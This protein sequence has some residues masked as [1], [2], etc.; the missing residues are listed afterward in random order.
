MILAARPGKH[1]SDLF[2]TLALGLILTVAIAIFYSR[3]RHAGYIWDDEQHLTQNPVIVGPLGF[4]KIWTSAR[5]VY[6]PLV[7]TTF[8]T[9]HKFVG[10]NPLPYHALNVAWH[11][12]SA[13]LFWRVLAQLRIRAA[14]LGAAIWA[15]HPVVVQS[16]A[17][18]TEMKNTQS[19][20]FYLLAISLF[21]QSRDVKYHRVLYLL[22]LVSFVAAIT[23]KPSTVI[24]PAVLA[25]CLW[26]REGSFRWR[27]L[28]QLIPFLLISL[29]ASAWT[30]WEQKFHAGATGPEWAQTALQRILI[31][32]DAIWFYLLKL[33]WPYP[34]IFIYPRWNVD[35][36]QPLAYVPLVVL[37]IVAI[38]LFVVRNGLLRPVFFAFAYFV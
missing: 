31:S 14:W 1:F 13:L 33:I 9:L 26:W 27:D 7:L 20:V 11:A 38:F 18:I 6:Y 36:A 2:R 10:L 35:P 30:I 21:L 5:A 37:V 22:S 4:A 17:W 23:S 28:R 24:L 12:L 34:L 8:W 25:L 19:A 15:L 29:I 3:V 16:V 32:A